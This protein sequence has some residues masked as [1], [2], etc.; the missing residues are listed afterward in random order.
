MND[1]LP[2]LAIVVPYHNNQE[3]LNRL[4]NSI[5]VDRDIEIIV[6]DDQSDAP[7]VIPP[8]YVSYARILSTTDGRRWAGAARNIGL[9][10]ARAEYVCFADSDDSFETPG[11]R[12]LMNFLRNEYFD[13]CIARVDG[14]MSDSRVVNRRHV[15]YNQIMDEYK[16]SGAITSL[17]RYHVPWGK[18]FRREFLTEKGVVF[19][20]II[21]SNDV[22]FSLRATLE[23]SRIVT[24]G[25]TLYRV[26]ESSD[27]L[28]K[29]NSHSVLEARF[30][31]LCSYNDLLRERG[32]GEHTG[33]MSGQLFRLF[34]FHRRFF[35]KS[36][37][38]V[39]RRRYRIFYSVAH[40]RQIISRY[41]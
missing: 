12:K 17:F 25:E 23:A 15:K 24:F 2:L 16:S 11:L 1:R 18:V 13:L 22:M 31:A 30:W 21:A 26:T 7:P 4:I 6:V 3:E 8:P 14:A 40:V 36:L 38:V 28:T 33:A 27:S 35:W 32:F 37:V 20:E 9:A 19:D 34:R 5:C 29:S 41:V 39:L 10:S